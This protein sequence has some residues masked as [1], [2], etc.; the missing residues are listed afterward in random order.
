MVVPL[1]K[2]KGSPDGRVTGQSESMLYIN[3][4]L[5]NKTKISIGKP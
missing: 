3:Q 1:L 5:K 4:G 2:V